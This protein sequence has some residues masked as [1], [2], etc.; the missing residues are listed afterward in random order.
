MT[1]TITPAVAADNDDCLRRKVGNLF[2]KGTEGSN[3]RSAGYYNGSYYEYGAG[4]RFTGVTV[5]KGN[6][7]NSAYLKLTS[8]DNT[9]VDTVNARISAESADDAAAFSTEAD[10]DTRYTGRTTAKVDWAVPHFVK[11]TQYTSPNIKT[12]IQEI[13]NR[14]GWA[15]GNHLVLFWEDFDDRSSH[16]NNAYRSAYAYWESHAKCAVL[17]ITYTPGVNYARTVT[18]LMGGKDSIVRKADRV[19]LVVELFGGKDSL[20]FTLGGHTRNAAGVILPGCTVV[21]LRT[22]DNAY[23]A[24]TVSDASGHF[25]FL[26]ADKTVTYYLVA[27]LAGSPNVAGT[28]YKDITAGKE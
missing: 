10:F 21:L 14:S 16:T 22:S 27:F 2:A 9:S 18:E 15:S 5:G 3:T 8:S 19:R 20:M 25:S 7:V 12:V 6:T 11:D 4:F 13:V 28:T 17:E 24:S 26:V 23:I 1:T